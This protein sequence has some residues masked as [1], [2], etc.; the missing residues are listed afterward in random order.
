MNLKK[1][2]VEIDSKSVKE[3]GLFE[4]YASVF[5]NIDQG[6]DIVAAG[7]FKKSIDNKAASNIKML[8]QHQQ[9]KPIGVWS[10]FSE[11]SNGLYVKGNLALGTTLG[12][13]T[14]E[15]MKLGAVDGMSIGFYSL[16][17]DYDQG[18]RTI[19]TAD[20]RE[21]SI[22]TFPMNE[23]ATVTTVKSL[24][25]FT[26]EDLESALMNYG[27]SLCDAKSIIKSGLQCTI[28]GAKSTKNSLYLSDVIKSWQDIRQST[29]K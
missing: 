24:L 27:V 26:Q 3:N 20:L 4:G 8:W 6:R 12:K 1:I 25:D 23:S 18:I 5:G 16:D 14:Y 9:D 17:E 19:K 11:D 21:V 2:S 28:N 7:A 10:S 13:D 15:L 22:V 29:T